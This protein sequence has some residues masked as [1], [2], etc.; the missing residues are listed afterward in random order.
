MHYVLLAHS[1]VRWFVLLVGLA[2]SVS[3]I[4]LL[5]RGPREN[6]KLPRTLASVYLALLDLQVLLGLALMVGAPPVRKV[7]SGHAVVMLAAV[8]LAHVLRVRARKAPEA[9]TARLL[10]VFYLL[11]LALI[12]L[13]IAMAPHIPLGR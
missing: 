2:G 13:G 8:L 3:A 7:A 9:S 11:P 12:I 10:T 5:A 1:L 6:G 4:V